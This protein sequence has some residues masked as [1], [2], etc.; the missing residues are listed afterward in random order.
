MNPGSESVEHSIGAGVS[1][2]ARELMDKQD[3]SVEFAS[4]ML[5]M[6]PEEVA[7][8]AAEEEFYDCL[9]DIEPEFSCVGAGIGGGFTDTSELHVMKYDEAMHMADDKEV[10]EWHDAVAEEKERMCAKIHSHCTFAIAEYR[11]TTYSYMH[12]APKPAPQVQEDYSDLIPGQELDF[13][14]A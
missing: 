5:L 1:E 14:L 3:E 13:S 10:E 12:P 2:I 9:A 7:L 6:Q 4:V 8:C 11:A